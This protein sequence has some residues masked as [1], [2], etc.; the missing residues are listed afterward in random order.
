MAKDDPPP[1]DDFPFPVRK[2]GNGHFWA[3]WT[4]QIIAFVLGA[5]TAAYVVGGK[6]EILSQVLVRV[7]KLEV[8]TERMDANGTNRSH[9]KDDDQERLITDNREAIN[10]LKKKVEPINVMQVKIENLEKRAIGEDIRK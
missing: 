7:A 4:R 3:S 1:K 6:S 9:W 5:L 8:L 2:N 10:E